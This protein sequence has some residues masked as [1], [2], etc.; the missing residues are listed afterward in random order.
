M[1]D[2][3]ECQCEAVKM[4]S[5]MANIYALWIDEPNISRYEA[6]FSQ[7]ME[8]M[9][10]H[11]STQASQFNISKLSE[12]QKRL[13]TID[14]LVNDAIVG[15][16]KFVSAVEIIRTTIHKNPIIRDMFLC[17]SPEVPESYLSKRVYGAMELLN[18]G[19]PAEAKDDFNEI[20][21][22][23]TCGV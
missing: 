12:V 23:L 21:R 6:A 10:N 15:K 14:K 13:E 22:E 19:E 4:L 17:N 8:K 16:E 18:V 5:H 11:L 7:V 9:S 2:I 3:K 1:S 20:Y